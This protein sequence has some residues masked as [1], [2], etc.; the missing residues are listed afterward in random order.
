MSVMSLSLPVSEPPAYAIAPRALRRWAAERL[1]QRA[2]NDGGAVYTFALSGS[3]CNNRPLE[4]V[5]T[6]AV[7]A[8]G[9]I[10]SATAQP[11]GHDTGCDAMCAAA[12]DGRRFLAEAGG[13]HEAVGL[14]VRQAAFR[15]WQEEPSGCFCTAGNCRHKWRNVFQTLH[16]AA[17][18]RDEP[19]R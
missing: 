6:V 17:T 14:T 18:N 11:A 10:E 12:C 1:H 7:G 8:D 9:R 16:Y 2:R 15:D 5:M 13:C 19:R 3:T 4:A